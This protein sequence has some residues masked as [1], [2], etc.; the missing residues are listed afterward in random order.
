MN[1]YD[2]L[3]GMGKLVKEHGLPL[4]LLLLLASWLRPKLDRI[5]DIALRIDGKDEKKARDLPGRIFNV[6]RINEQV[7]AILRDILSEF[8]ASRVYVFSYHNGGHSLTGLDFAKASCTHEVVS[9]GTRP[10]QALLQNLPVTMFCAF[11]RRV[12]DGKGVRCENIDCFK[13][14]DPSTY[15]TLRMQSIRSI[16]CVGLYAHG[17]QPIGFLGIDYCDD[18]YSMGDEEF[19]EMES[20]AA[21]VATLMCLASNPLCHGT[22]GLEDGQ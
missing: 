15:E 9:L 20:L 18:T 2:W 7:M 10:Q 16:Y 1:E 6:M 14:S 8:S 5:F 3:L 11:N 19:H 22:C 17:G 4:I 12:L 21:R 13:N